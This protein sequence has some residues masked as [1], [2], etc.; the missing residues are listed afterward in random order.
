M[1]HGFLFSI[2]LCASITQAQTALNEFYSGPIPE[3]YE[4]LEENRPAIRDNDLLNEKI[5]DMVDVEL[6]DSIL[7]NKSER[8]R[9]FF[10]GWLINVFG[11]K[12]RAIEMVKKKYVGTTIREARVPGDDILFTEYDVN[13]DIY[14][15]INEYLDMAWA[16]REYQL[17]RNK[18]MRKKDKTKPPYIAP[19]KNGDRSKYRLHCEL[20]PPVGYRAM[21]NEKFYPCQRPNSFAAHESFGDPA[22]TIGLYGPFVADCNHSCHPEIHPYEWIWWYDLNPKRDDE[23]NQSWYIGMFREGSNRFPR[24]SKGPREGTISIPFIFDVNKGSNSISIEHLVFSKMDTTGLKQKFNLP[25][26]AFTL[27]FKQRDFEVAGFPISLKMSNPM[28]RN[29]II[30]WFTDV[31]Y[32]DKSRRVSGRLNLAVKAEDVYTAKISFE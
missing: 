18:L 3:A 9:V 8:H 29:G 27:D 16:G 23:K 21:L 20:T 28:T 25:E 12:W 14:S 11:Y 7:K 26:S 30:A 24:W 4:M 5:I 10:L 1:K 17:K 15:N 19:D 6:T 22:P 31:T 32:D 2:L 13:M